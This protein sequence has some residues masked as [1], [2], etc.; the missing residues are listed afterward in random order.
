MKKSLISLLCVVSLLLCACGGADDIGNSTES[1]YQHNDD[2]EKIYSHEGGVGTF[3]YPDDIYNDYLTVEREFDGT[4]QNVVDILLE[5]GNYD[6]GLTVNSYYIQDE[7]MFIDF[8]IELVK[9]AHGGS[10]K[11]FFVILGTT[12]TLISCFGV[13]YVRLTVEGED[14]ITAHG[15][16]SVPISFQG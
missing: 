16:Y 3:Y 13:K 1:G 11:E 2:A 15:D 8:G 5:L 12:N 7:T 4:P 14:L 10:A 9:E 6:D